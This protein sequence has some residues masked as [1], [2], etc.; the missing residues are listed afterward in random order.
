MDGLNEEDLKR[1]INGVAKAL[2]EDDDEGGFIDKLGAAV[3]K[4]QHKAVMDQLY[5]DLGK[6]LW[7]MFLRG[8]VMGVFAIAAWGAAH[9][10]GFLKW[11]H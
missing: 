10:M 1:I 4:A 5:H 2:S 11:T 9:S 7:G 3:A 6:G 8:V